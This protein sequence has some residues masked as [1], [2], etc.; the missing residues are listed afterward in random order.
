[1]SVKFVSRAARL[2]GFVVSPLLTAPAAAADLTRV[3]SMRDAPVAVHAAAV[4]RRGA[5]DAHGAP[6]AAS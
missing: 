2:L 4:D 1:M 5:G 3:S 6:R